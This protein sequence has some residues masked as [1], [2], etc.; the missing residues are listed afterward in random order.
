MAEE[1]KGR[2]IN[3]LFKI[4]AELTELAINLMNEAIISFCEGNPEDMKNKCEETIRI[5]KKQDRLCEYMISRVFSGETM[6]FSRADRVKLIEYLDS[7]VD[8]VEMVAQKLKLYTPKKSPLFLQR[9]R[10]AALLNRKT[11][12]AIKRLYYAILD[13]FDATYG[14]IQEITDLRRNVRKERWNLTSEIYASDLNF[15]DFFFYIDIMRNLAHVADR[16]EDYADRIHAIIVKY[17]L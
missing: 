13:D 11:G 14:I 6:V 2:K 3:D 8:E 5:E 4:N 9:L 7:I 17:R 10:E 12:S 15:K 16:C 1:F